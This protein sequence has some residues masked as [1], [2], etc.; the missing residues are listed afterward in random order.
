MHMD[1]SDLNPPEKLVGCQWHLSQH[2]DGL[3]VSGGL[4]GQAHQKSLCLSN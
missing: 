2:S 3:G 1:V 4:Q